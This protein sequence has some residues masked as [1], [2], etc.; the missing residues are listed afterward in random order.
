MGSAAFPEPMLAR[1]GPLP[2]GSGWR[3][4]VKWDGF[5]ALVSTER[6][7]RVRS[8][9]GWA[10][11]R[12]LPELESMPLGLVLD[13]ELVAWGDGGI[14]DFD[15]LCGRL[16]H[17]D[18][19]VA[20]TFMVFDLLRVD[21]HSLLDTPYEQRRRLLEELDVNG[22]VWFTPNVFDDGAALW[23]VCDRTLE[24]V[25]AKRLSSLYRPGHRGGGWVKRKSPTWPRRDRELETMRRKLGAPAAR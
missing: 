18:G 12:L 21:G 8:R 22:A 25:V 7:L 4:E 3:F 23:Q 10:M 2:V 15:R 19:D 1:S 11:T 17:H 5:R 14:P 16:L 9:N 6:A 20:V 24:G 13:G